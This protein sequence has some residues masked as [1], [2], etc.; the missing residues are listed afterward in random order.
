MFSF[1]RADAHTWPREFAS[2]PNPCSGERA[3]ISLWS[4]KEWGRQQGGRARHDVMSPVPPLPPQCSATPSHLIWEGYSQ[5]AMTFNLISF[6][7]TSSFSLTLIPSCISTHVCTHPLLCDSIY[8]T[9]YT[10]VLTDLIER[11]APPHKMTYYIFHTRCITNKI[12]TS[13]SDTNL[14]EMD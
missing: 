11:T 8:R 7:F 13:C 2:P 6:S 12:I 14:Q 4:S 9:H 3:F 10:F 1:P 5:R